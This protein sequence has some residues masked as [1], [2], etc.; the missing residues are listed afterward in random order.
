MP[1]IQDLSAQG[2]DVDKLHNTVGKIY[3]TIPL[4]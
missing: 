4:A 3:M 2:Q 1:Y